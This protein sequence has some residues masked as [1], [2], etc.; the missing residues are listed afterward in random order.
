MEAVL[1][2][3]V[4]DPG[5]NTGWNY[6]EIAD[7]NKLKYLT[8]GTTVRSHMGVAELFTIYNPDLVVFESFHMYPGMAKTLSWNS[9]YPCEVI[10]VIRYMCDKMG[11]QYY[12]QA[13]SIKKFSG[14]LDNDWVMLRQREQTTE[15]C[16]DAF[17]HLKYFRRNTYKKLPSKL[18]K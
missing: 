18:L 2:V 17:L 9:F 14:G 16:K 5:E 4:F 15:H 12:E 1:K 3:L 11:I 13:P 7:G 8:G 6:A 10:G